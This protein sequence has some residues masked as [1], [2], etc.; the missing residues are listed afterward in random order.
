MSVPFGRA[1]PSLLG[2]SGVFGPGLSE[3]EVE[4]RGG[5]AGAAVVVAVGRPVL[6]GCPKR[7]RADAEQEKN[8]FGDQAHRVWR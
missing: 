2:W 6:S 4:A 1:G 7:G 8:G 5:D 3:G